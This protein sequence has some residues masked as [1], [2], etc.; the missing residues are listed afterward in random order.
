MAEQTLTSQ[1]QVQD[2]L[3]IKSHK[4]THRKVNVMVLSNPE[5]KTRPS[6]ATKHKLKRLGL[7]PLKIL[8]SSKASATEVNAKLENVCPKLKLGGGF[9]ILIQHPTQPSELKLIEPQGAGYDSKFL[10][11]TFGVK[12]VYVRPKKN[13][14]ESCQVSSERNIVNTLNFPFIEIINLSLLMR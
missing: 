2:R 12:I 8:L 13:L 4:N 14:D 10:R 5:R 9:D 6:T 3:P 1:S 7:G 11:D